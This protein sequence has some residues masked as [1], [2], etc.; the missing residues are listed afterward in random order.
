MYEI[1]RCRG[2]KSRKGISVLE[3]TATK[4]IIAAWYDDNT[5]LTKEQIEEELF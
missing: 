2:F 3:E 4:N 5:P 1:W